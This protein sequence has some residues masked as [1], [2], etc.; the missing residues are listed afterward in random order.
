VPAAAKP[1]IARK[2]DEPGSEAEPDRPGA[3]GEGA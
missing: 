2:A 1:L 3:D